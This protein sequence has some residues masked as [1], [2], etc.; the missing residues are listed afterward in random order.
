MYTILLSYLGEQDG[1]KEDTSDFLISITFAVF[2]SSPPTPFPHD[3]QNN[4]ISILT[5]ILEYL[6]FNRFELFID[7]K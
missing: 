6:I 2:V 1:E 3:H 7:D 5:L 4:Q